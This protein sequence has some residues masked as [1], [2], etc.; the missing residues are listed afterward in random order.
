MAAERSEQASEDQRRPV[1]RPPK[2]EP[3]PIPDSFE[4]VVT[5]LVTPPRDES[6]AD[7]G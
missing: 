6:P 4:H 7:A 2:P 1:G 3:A 5:A